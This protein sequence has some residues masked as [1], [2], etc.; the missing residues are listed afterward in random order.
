M[1]HTAIRILAVDDHTAI[2]Q[3]LAAIIDSEADMEIIASASD[4]REAIDQY[5]RH[6]PDV[7][8]MDLQLPAMSG[9]EAIRAI[10]HEDAGARIVVLTMYQ[11]DDD[12]NRAFE[13]G[14]AAYLL[15]DTPADNLVHTIREV[16]AGKTSATPTS[17][18]LSTREDQ[19]MQLIA[20]G[21]RNKEISGRL[22]ISEDTVQAHVKSIFT[23]LHVHDRTAA[24]AIAIKRGIVHLD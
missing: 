21:L 10:R 9:F 23:K 2:R 8:L 22:G 14:A 3:G 1:P 18:T 6:R 15:K 19:V 11:G 4:G 24:L 7:V 12:V 5:K 20:I 17:R 13:A 16:H